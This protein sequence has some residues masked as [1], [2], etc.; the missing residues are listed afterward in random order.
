MKEMT[1]RTITSRKRNLF[2]GLFCLCLLIDGCVREDTGN[3]SRYSLSVKVVDTEGNDITAS[4]VVS[5]VTFYLFNENGFVQIIPQ[6]PSAVF[7]WQKDK[8]KS[9]TLV[10]WGN[11]KTD[12]LKVPQLAVGTSL[13]AACVELL[14]RTNGSYLPSTDLFYGKLELSE[15][16]TRSDPGGTNVTLSLQ[17]MAS[18]I[19]I[20]TSSFREHFGETQSGENCRII[21]RDAGNALNFLGRTTGNAAGYEPDVREDS[22][23]DFYASNFYV[24]PTEEDSSLAI[25]IYRG[26]ERLFTTTTDEEGEPLQAPAGKQLNVTIDFAHA[27]AKVTVTVSPWQQAGQQTEM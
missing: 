2:L 17:R 23:G 13:E 24:F 21:V 7:V 14:Q 15:A 1:Y 22:E 12:S 4:G 20:R 18:A 8:D 19:S 16:D 5:S 26:D 11:L 27:R 10:A 3:C 9:L 6:E 25:D